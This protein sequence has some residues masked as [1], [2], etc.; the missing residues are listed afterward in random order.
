MIARPKRKHHQ[1]ANDRGNREY[2]RREK[3]LDEALKNTFR[4]PIRFQSSNRACLPPMVSIRQELNA[5]SFSLSLCRSMSALGHKRTFAPQKVM[6]ALPPKSDMCG[7]LAYV[8]FVPKAD[9]GL[10]FDHLVGKGE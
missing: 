5:R 10:L 1:D 9:I 2:W 6:S 7:A 8:R 4:R 3:A